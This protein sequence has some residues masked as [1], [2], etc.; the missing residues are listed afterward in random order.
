MRRPIRR[1]MFAA[2]LGWLDSAQMEK[3]QAHWHMPLINHQKE[4]VGDIHV[5][6]ED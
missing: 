3:L 2:A 6:I 5:R 1:W 4:L